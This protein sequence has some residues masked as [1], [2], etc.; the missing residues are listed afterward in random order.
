MARSPLVLVSCVS[1]DIQ[2]QVEAR[3]VQR[4]QY[5]DLVRQRTELD[6]TKAPFQAAV[7]AANQALQQISDSADTVTAQ[8]EAA[9]ARQARSEAKVRQIEDD[10]VGLRRAAAEAAHAVEHCKRELAVGRCLWRALQDAGAK[11]SLVCRDQRGASTWDT[12]TL[13]YGREEACRAVVTTPQEAT[14]LAMERCST[15]P[16]P[17][18]VSYEQSVIKLKEMQQHLR[19]HQKAHGSL[20]ETI[21]ALEKSNATYVAVLARHEELA[22]LCSV[23]KATR[24]MPSERLGTRRADASSHA[25]ARRRGILSGA[26]RAAMALVA[27]ADLDDQGAC[28]P[29]RGNAGALWC[30]S[31]DILP[32]VCADARL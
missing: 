9:V 12:S 7:D 18:R 13:T 30:E 10:L 1:G 24:I 16:G 3:D 8:V 15:R 29:S 27:G 5:R 32:G 17:V 4:N 26:G 28:D 19:Q 2:E 23:R 11:A 20:E 22:Q 14:H 6:A 31:A 21:A 25:P